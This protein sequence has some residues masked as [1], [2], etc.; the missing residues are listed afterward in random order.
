MG[1][2]IETMGYTGFYNMIVKTQ[3]IDFILNFKFN[4]TEMNVKLINNY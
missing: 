3:D 1:S 2:R 4:K